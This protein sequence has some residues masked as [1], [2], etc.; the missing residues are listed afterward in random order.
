MKRQVRYDRMNEV[1][2]EYLAATVAAEALDTRLRNELELLSP[3]KL[4]VRDFQKFRDHLSGTYLIRLFAEFEAGLRDLWTDGFKQSSVPRMRDLLQ[5]IAARRL[6]SEDAFDGANA[7]RSYRNALVHDRD[8]EV[9]A[10][11]FRDARRR[12]SHYFSYVPLDW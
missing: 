2:R 10:M 11:S 7:V 4:K 5:G 1:Y 12:L 9:E 8:T 3:H 6:I